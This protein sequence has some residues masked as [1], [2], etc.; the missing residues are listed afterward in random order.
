MDDSKSTPFSSDEIGNEQGIA[1]FS[2]PGRWHGAAM[3]SWI[4]QGNPDL[5]EI[6]KYLADNTEIQWSVRQDD[7]A[8]R[9]SIG[10]EVFI[11][12]AAGKS[13]AISGVVARG[14]VRSLPA[15]L[16]DDHDGMY[17]VKE[18][19]GVERRVRLQLTD[20]LLSKKNTINRDWL[21]ND[22]VLNDL[23]ILRFAN[24]TNFAIN[25]GQAKRLR[26]LCSRTGNDWNRDES[27]AGLWLYNATIDSPISKTTESPVA[28]VANLIG[29]SVGGVYNKVMN[30]RAI[31]PRDSRAGLKS[32]ADADKSVWAEFFDSE[33]GQLDVDRL[34]SEFSRVWRA[35][36]L[37]PSD[38]EIDYQEE[39]P[40]AK[41]DVDKYKDKKPAK[42]KK[43][44]QKTTMQQAPP[45]NPNIGELAL[46]E[47]GYKCESDSSHVTFLRD[48]GEQFMEK[49]HLIPM[50]YYYEFDQSIDHQCNIV[51]LC[52]NC[53]RKIHL[54]PP[55]DKQ[56]LLE[57]LLKDR[58]DRLRS[59]YQVSIADM[60]D[61]Y[62][63]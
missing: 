49:H 32:S 25:S 40:P 51:A 45:R 9:V 58:L 5:F 15:D 63:L 1:H 6:D 38:S 27:L 46:Q 19:Q 4:F 22:P 26:A 34:D 30:F 23:I 2:I 36:L 24:A 41:K 18:P 57:A 29:R 20:R 61:Y 50:E 59:F 16:P 14:I 55:A 12:R 33:S 47:A 44:K 8:T 52:P 43:P 13:K 3:R 56:I 10:D 31:D 42:T 11:W 53:H 17:W 7:C 62:D 48:D 35:D 21:E 60:F 37:K 54:G 28:A 39:A